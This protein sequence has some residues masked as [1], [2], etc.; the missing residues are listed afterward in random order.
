MKKNICSF[1][2]KLKSKL[3]FFSSPFIFTRSIR[4]HVSLLP[5]DLQ[6]CISVYMASQV[7]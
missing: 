3:L 2:Q 4:I 6:T 7:T 5:R 1:V